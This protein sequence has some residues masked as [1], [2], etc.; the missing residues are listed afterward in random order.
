MSHQVVR[1]R[2]PIQVWGLRLLMLTAVVAGGWGLFEYGRYQGGYDAG[3]AQERA[4]AHQ[5][6][7][8][9]MEQDNTRLRERLAIVQRST[10]IEKRA[11]QELKGE[12]NALQEEILELKQELAFYRGIVSPGDVKKGLTLQRFELAP[13]SNERSYR[14]KM[15]LTQVLNNSNVAYGNIAVS[16]IGLQGDEEQE[17]NLEQVSELDGELRFRFRYFQSFEGELFLPEDFI[18]SKVKLVVKP[19]SR[20]HNKL[21]ETVDWMVQES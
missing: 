3:A 13:G 7:V 17:L 18:P 8:Q 9:Q 5:Q 2:P 4:L 14:Y 1:A 19:S 20:K 16:I 6:Q 12:V 21:T 15:M 10:Q 11:Y